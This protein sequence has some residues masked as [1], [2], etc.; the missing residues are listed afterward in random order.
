MSSCNKRKCFAS[1]IEQNEDLDEDITSRITIEWLR[2]L[3]GLCN[4]GI[5]FEKVNLTNCV[6]TGFF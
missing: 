3:R 4:I 6:K 2:S 1:I 5:S